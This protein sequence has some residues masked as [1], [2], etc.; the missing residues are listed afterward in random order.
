MQRALLGISLVTVVII[1]AAPSARARQADQPSPVASPAYA[2]TVLPSLGGE[3]SRAYDISDDGLV[4]GHADDEQNRRRAVV[5]RLSGPEDLG[6]LGGDHATAIALNEAGQIVGSSTTMPNQELSKA[7]TFAT[8]WQEGGAINLGSLGGDISIAQDI[9]AAGVVVGAS[10]T[11]PGVEF[12]LAATEGIQAFL[13]RTGKMT[14]LGTLGG[15]F[16][17]AMAM[18]DAGQVVGLSRTAAGTN[19]A[20][21]WQDGVMIDLGAPEGHWSAAQDIN[22][23]HQIVGI[24][25]SDMSDSTPLQWLE[26]KRVPLSAGSFRGAA[27]YAVNDA[28]E[29][30]GNAQGPHALLWQ[31]GQIVDLGAHIPPDSG[32]DDLSIARNINATG[33]IVGWGLRDSTVRAFVMSRLPAEATPVA[34]ICAGHATWFTAS[35]QAMTPLFDALQATGL[36]QDADRSLTPIQWHSLL[37]ASKA[38]VTA[39]DDIIPPPARAEWHAAQRKL[40]LVYGAYAL[41]KLEDGN[42]VSG[43]S[44][45]TWIDAIFELDR[46]IAN[47][48]HCPPP[49]A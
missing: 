10:S 19:H 39:M 28:S 44:A 23:H 18:N 31:E 12:S 30:V 20:F 49:A 22:N 2:I 26:N 5:W 3:S 16:S 47:A 36:S 46:A 40:A 13:W 45:A 38:S 11:R 33:Q 24:A 9:N 41:A 7:G 6:T 48:P 15:D 29:I 43:P 27:T 34:G 4:V 1:L 17:F 35:M 21:L 32:W 25:Q 37:D 42:D 8:L 14:P